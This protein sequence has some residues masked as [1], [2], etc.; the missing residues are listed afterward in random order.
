MKRLPLAL[1]AAYLLSL[2]AC[3]ES[4]TEPTVAGGAVRRVGPWLVDDQGRV[5]V[6]HGFNIVR[7]TAPFVATEFGPSDARLLADEGFTVARIAFIWEAVEPQ[8]GDYDDEYIGRV[9]AL[10][11]LLG[12]YGI[13]TLVDFHQDLWSRATH[14]DGAPAW[15][16]LGSDFNKSFAAFWRDDPGPGGVG[17]QTRFVRAWEHVARAL[18]DHRNIIG[19][20]LLN[21]PYPGSD[22]PA[23]C[24]PFTRCVEFERG[25]LATFY[26]RVI[27]AIRT[28]GAAQVIMPEG[29][30][31]SGQQAPVLPTFSDPQSGFN[32]H[33]YCLA[34]QLSSVEVPV[35]QPSPQAAA[36]APIEQ[37]NIE[38]FTSYAAQL[39][40]PGLLS[41]F[42]CNDVNPDNAQVVDDVASTFT[43]WTAWMYYR[44]AA[45]PANCS[46]Q[47]LLLDDT[48]PG[49]EANAKQDKLDAFSVP[50][51][52]AIA[53]TP[54]STQ[55]DRA[56]R[57]YTLSYRSGAVTGAELRPEAL[58][59]VFVPARMYPTGYVAEVRGARIRSSANAR[60]LL[61][62]AGPDSSVSVTVTPD[63]AG[64]R[65][66]P[67]D[68]RTFPPS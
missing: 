33:F 9:L 14:G 41:E 2:A 53:G 5:I 58:T 61:L 64:A 56:S 38:R 66:V 17:I 67:D 1:L 44:A 3:G 13:R 46:R 32:F 26:G 31:E 42:S 7:K 62:S 34:T 8:P 28:A 4:T 35:G 43:S 36:C 10:D 18:R 12:R 29:V 27:A 45:D 16:T 63:N 40:V 50:Y 20:D 47:G 52:A 25:A 57:T 15:A 22:Y 65:S 30:A 60:W 55:L 68:G 21:E 24:G 54:E 59:A 39:D 49:S 37:R 6:V 11:A 19:L 23:P 51:A 48:Q